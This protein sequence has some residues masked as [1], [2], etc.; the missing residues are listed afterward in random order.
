MTAGPPWAAEATRASSTDAA[1]APLVHYGGRARVLRLWRTERR[2]EWSVLTNQAN[3]RAA[4]SGAEPVRYTRSNT[5]L[6]RL[7]MDFRHSLAG[8]LV[9]GHL[10][11][12]PPV[13]SVQ[14]V[15]LS[16]GIAAI[17]HSTNRPT[18]TIRGSPTA[19][20]T[21][22][23]LASPHAFHALLVHLELAVLP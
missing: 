23:I 10:L 16:T 1:I 17:V 13:P 18:A 20:C 14:S 19:R 15:S 8:Q 9:L 2:W 11:C 21:L 5:C 4:S 6:Y 3:R 7:M 22:F 12:P